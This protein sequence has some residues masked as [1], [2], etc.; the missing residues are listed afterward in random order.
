MQTEELFL[1]IFDWAK[2]RYGEDE[3]GWLTIHGTY[4]TDKF[5]IKRP[6]GG[7]S[8]CVYIDD[9]QISALIFIDARSKTSRQPF[10]TEIFQLD[11]PQ[12]FEKI[13]AFVG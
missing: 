10:E 7:Y 2:D 13:N 4:L 11:D 6:D 5:R 8:V 9:K 3:V 12:L 1:S